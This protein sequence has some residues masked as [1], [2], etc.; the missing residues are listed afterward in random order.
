MAEI[1]NFSGF[2][3]AGCEAESWS[4]EVLT[5]YGDQEAVLRKMEKFEMNLSGRRVFIFILESAGSSELS[6]FERATPDTY[7]VY[8]WRGRPQRDLVEKLNEAIIRNKGVNCVGE[9]SKAILKTLPGLEEQ[10]DI[11]A[12]ASARAAFGH[13]IL[14]HKEYMSAS[15]YLM[16]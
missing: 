3:A 8:R 10:R 1:P 11:P 7:S 12:P 15:A 16:C 9:Q 6:F 2:S 5:F 4:P 13:Q 14:A